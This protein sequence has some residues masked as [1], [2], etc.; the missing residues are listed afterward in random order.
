MITVALVN[1]IS[2]TCFEDKTAKHVWGEV[3]VRCQ[4]FVYLNYLSFT[5]SCSSSGPKASP[6][7]TAT[8]NYSTVTDG[9]GCSAHRQW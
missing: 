1:S 4:L 8:G 9:W 3:V 5:H 6:V 2:K 7:S